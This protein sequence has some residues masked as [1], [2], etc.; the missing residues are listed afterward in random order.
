MFQ[1]GSN[2]GKASTAREEALLL[3]KPLRD[4]S[5]MAFL[6]IQPYSG[7]RLRISKFFYF[8]ENWPGIVE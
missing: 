7:W 3:M 1:I 8:C 6:T 4:S 5:E 2:S